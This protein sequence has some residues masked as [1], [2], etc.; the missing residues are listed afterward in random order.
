MEH[1]N[2]VTSSRGNKKASRSVRKYSQLYIHRN[3]NIEEVNNIGEWMKAH[4]WN[5]SELSDPW[6]IDVKDAFSISTARFGFDRS[7]V[8]TDSETG[9]IVEMFFSSP[10]T[11]PEQVH[12][13]FK[14]RRS[15]HVVV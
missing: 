6:V 4:G 3:Q 1:I 11:K 10:T 5:K 15:V 9:H 12:R 7:R 14:K 8:V 2:R 13:N